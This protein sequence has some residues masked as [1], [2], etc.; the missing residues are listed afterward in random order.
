MKEVQSINASLPIVSRDAGNLTVDKA[1]QP[2]KQRLG[3][4][5]ILS[6]SVT[7]FKFGHPEN[8]LSET[9]ESVSGIIRS[10]TPHLANEYVPIEVSF[11]G[12]SKVVKPIQSENAESPIVAMFDGRSRCNNALS[13]QKAAFPIDVR[14]SGSAISSS[15]EQS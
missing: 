9:V 5:V 1:E 3:I 11:A 2:E 6:G 15:D 13:L 10:I 14:L 4:T 12:N 7:D 8:A